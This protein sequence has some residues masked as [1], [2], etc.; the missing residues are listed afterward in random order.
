METLTSL[1]M[2]MLM[3]TTMIYPIEVL[4][5][6]SVVLEEEILASA[7]SEACNFFSSNH[8]NLQW[9]LRS[10]GLYLM[11]RWYQYVEK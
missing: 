3:G 6:I 5:D 1:N 10:P 7:G 9:L 11:L 2:L 4:K 8:S